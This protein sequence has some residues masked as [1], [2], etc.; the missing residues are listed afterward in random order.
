MLKSLVA[1]GA[2]AFALGGCADGVE[3][4]GKIFDAVGLS[5]AMQGPK[6]EP[7]MADR[8][9]LVLPPSTERLPD[10][11]NLQQPLQTASI[12]DKSWPMGPEEKAARAAADR[13]REHAAY[14]SGE[15][16]WQKEAFNDRGSRSG[17][18]V[19]SS[20]YGSCNELFS[21]QINQFSANEKKAPDPLAAARTSPRIPG[22]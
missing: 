6:P 17:S 11:N 13:A 1:V 18:N 22:N 15:K 10:P 19:R 8:A 14:C 12:N 7:K 21:S 4:N 3:L 20:P 16:T 9:P 2:L 5:S